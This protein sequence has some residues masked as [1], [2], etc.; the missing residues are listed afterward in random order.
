[1]TPVG[2]TPPG[3]RTFPGNLGAP[4]MV[5][6]AARRTRSTVA[7]APFHSP[8][9]DVILGGTSLRLVAPGL[10]IADAAP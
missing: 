1:T 10:C 9:H 7:P 2:L 8:T 5:D 6:A 4:V 3:P